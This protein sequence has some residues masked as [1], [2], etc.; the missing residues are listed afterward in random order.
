MLLLRNL[1]LITKK[2]C[3]PEFFGVYGKPKEFNVLFLPKREIVLSVEHA[4]EL[5]KNHIKSTDLKDRED[6]VQAYNEILL[7]N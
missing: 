1:H 4:K 2:Y 6:V 7:K 5:I 3:V